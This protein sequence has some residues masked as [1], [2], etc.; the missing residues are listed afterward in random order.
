MLISSKESETYPCNVNHFGFP[1]RLSNY[2]FSEGIEYVF[3]HE[4]LQNGTVPSLDVPMFVAARY[5]TNE[6][7]S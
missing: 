2:S 5:I 4:V 3:E 7:V 1:Y 6:F